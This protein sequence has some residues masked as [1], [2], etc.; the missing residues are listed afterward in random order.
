MSSLDLIF[1][2]SSEGKGW[3][4]QMKWEAYRK[5]YILILYQGEGQASAF[6]NQVLHLPWYFHR[7]RGIQLR[8]MGYIIYLSFFS[9]TMFMKN[10]RV[11]KHWIP[12]MRI[13]LLWH[14]H[15]E[16]R[17][18]SRPFRPP[19]GTEDRRPGSKWRGVGQRRVS[20]LWL[21][22]K[23]P[24]LLCGFRKSRY[25]QKNSN[26]DFLCVKTLTNSC[27]SH[28]LL[29]SFLSR[30]YCEKLAVKFNDLKYSDPYGR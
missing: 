14:N 6:P 25:F 16:V 9:Q 21:C 28:L 13:C 27:S 7:Y 18:F 12:K 23:Y 22:S 2:S 4:C 10:T 15:T 20:P 24:C 30:R 1:H 3:I 8:Q 17:V 29:Y 5:I 19:R 26:G 11:T